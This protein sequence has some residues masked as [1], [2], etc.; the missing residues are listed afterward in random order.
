MQHDYRLL[1]HRL[2]KGQEGWVVHRSNHESKSA[3]T[4]VRLQPAANHQLDGERTLRDARAIR[5]AALGGEPRL[6]PTLY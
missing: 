2:F 6:C 3:L 4:C 1:D 5:R